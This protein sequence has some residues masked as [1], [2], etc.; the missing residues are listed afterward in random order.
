MPSARGSEGWPGVRC[1]SRA[2]GEPGCLCP[3]R[4]LLVFW[5]SPPVAQLQQLPSHL[6]R[7]PAAESRSPSARAAGPA[8]WLRARPVTPITLSVPPG[9]GA[10]QGRARTPGRW[11]VPG[12]RL[13]RAKCGWARATG[14]A[15]PLAQG[16]ACP[17]GGALLRLTQR[18]GQRLPGCREPSYPERRGQSSCPL[19]NAESVLTRKW[20][21][22]ESRIREAG[23][24]GPDRPIAARW[25]GWWLRRQK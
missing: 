15:R 21:C 19:C 13:R 9:A 6:Q 11:A 18:P 22:A 14:S 7:A 24:R 16:P 3:R 4:L 5:R 25:E 1:G 23:H 8:L 17:P 2:A 12:R 20:L 10:R